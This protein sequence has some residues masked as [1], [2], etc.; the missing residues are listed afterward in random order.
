MTRYSRLLRE[1]KTQ[2]LGNISN[3][4]DQKYGALFFRRNRDPKNRTWGLGT[5]TY[6]I[7]ETRHDQN[8]P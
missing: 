3:S 1:P 6:I 2:E 7:G 8:D 4:Q 5:G